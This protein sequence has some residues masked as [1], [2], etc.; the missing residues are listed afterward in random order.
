MKPFSIHGAYQAHILYT[1]LLNNTVEAV[2]NTLFKSMLSNTVEADLKSPMA[3][4]EKKY[5]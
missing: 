2:L 4:N 1:S 3:Y 5:T